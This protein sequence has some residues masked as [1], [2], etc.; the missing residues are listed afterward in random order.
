M[1]IQELEW[2]V[3]GQALR[4]T[5]T[6]A[7]LTEVWAAESKALG[8][9][10]VTVSESSQ[11]KDMFSTKPEGASPNICMPE[12]TR[13]N[14]D[15]AYIFLLLVCWFSCKQPEALIFPL[16]TFTQAL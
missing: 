12:F 2:E 16:S 5:F 4:T 6:H 3:T 10:V 14:P 7:D 1:N 15:L 11:F 13:L 9:R 8:S